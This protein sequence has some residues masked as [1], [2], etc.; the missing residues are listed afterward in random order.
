MAE[1]DIRRYTME[2]IREMRARGEYVPTPD[3]APEI[4]LDE[5]FWKKAEEVVA[6]RRNKES[7]HLRLD[8][9]VLA[10]FRADGPG[11]LTRMAEVLKAYVESRRR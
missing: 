7:V 2:Q 1:E 9:Q 11:H 5:E 10:A 6:Q 3:D 4:E 8:P